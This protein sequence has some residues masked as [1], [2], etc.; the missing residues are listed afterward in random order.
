MRV[1]TCDRGQYRFAGTSVL[2][3]CC[4]VHENRRLTAD[5]VLEVDPVIAARRAERKQLTAE[6]HAEQF[7]DR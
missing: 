4:E 7:S 2:L 6:P 5:V 3:Y 1:S